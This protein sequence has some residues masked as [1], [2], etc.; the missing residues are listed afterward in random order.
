MSAHSKPAMTATIRFLETEREWNAPWVQDAWRRLQKE[1][2]NPNSLFST[3]DWFDNKHKTKQEQLRVAIVANGIEITA[4]A[5]LLLGQQEFDLKVC[6]MHLHTAQLL[7]GEGLTQRP[8]VYEP[9]FEAIFQ[10]F[11]V[12]AIHFRLLSTESPCWTA[13][14]SS[15]A[16]FVH[17]HDRFKMHIVDLP[18]SFDA[19]LTGRFDSSHRRN[20]KHRMQVLRAQGEHRLWRC[21]ACSAGPECAGLQEKG[22]LRL[23]R[24]SAPED[25]QEFLRAGS[26]VAQV[27]WQ[28]ANADYLIRETPEWSAHLSDLAGRGL[29]RSY[30]L[31][32]GPA[33]CAYA[34][35]F[36]GGG[37]YQAC[38]IGYDPSMSK[39]SPGIV[40]L[41]LM[42]EDLIQYDPPGKLNFGEGEDEYKRRFG[43]ETSEV[44]NVTMLR[45]SILGRMRVAEFETYQFLRGLRRLKN[46][47][48]KAR[49][50][51]VSRRR[52]IQFKGNAQPFGRQGRLTGKRAE[53]EKYL[54]PAAGSAPVKRGR[55]DAAKSGPR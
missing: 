7:G 13:V 11:G 22:E 51:V 2:T 14:E 16:G 19:Y 15:R 42:I 46:R 4:I 6:R 53:H 31:W 54:E 18:Q 50:G 28:A 3:L 1:T 52:Q 35:G 49:S 24:I 44:A 34:L 9:L 30:L 39:F 36:Q 25:V 8:E 5:P 23:Q 47:A 20:L 41:L 33:P 32:C 38:F 48:V 12:A 10:T 26:K 55:L 37:S 43:T 17:V 45:R 21:S 29:L 40:M 27:S